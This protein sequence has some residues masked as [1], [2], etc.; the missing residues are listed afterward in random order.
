MELS[1]GVRSCPPLKAPPEGGSKRKR[2][3]GREE[4]P[5]CQEVRGREKNLLIEKKRNKSC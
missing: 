2:R 4:K 3:E 5:V 1:E